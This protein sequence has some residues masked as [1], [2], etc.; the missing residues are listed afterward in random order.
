[1]L[2]FN[3]ASSL[4][5]KWFAPRISMRRRP[6]PRQMI[7]NRLD[8]GQD[9]ARCAWG[10]ER[11][12]VPNGRRGFAERISVT[13]ELKRCRIADP[14]Y[15]FPVRRRPAISRRSNYLESYD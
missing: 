2:L 3:E 4:K 8:I 6:F 10:K 13:V 11:Y 5:R 1:M 9:L 15:R 12:S 14:Q 7:L